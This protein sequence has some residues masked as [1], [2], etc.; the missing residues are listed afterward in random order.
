[1]KDFLEAVAQAQEIGIMWIL[2]S[3]MTYIIYHFYKKGETNH[4][5]NVE[6]IYALH[7]RLDAV[8]LERSD[9]KAESAALIERVNSL[10]AR[11]ETCV[12]ELDYFKFKD[13]SH[14]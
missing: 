12:K 7:K 3:V 6:E 9:C 11:F 5:R 14:D 1:M 4:Q 2:I 10:T 13:R 8:E